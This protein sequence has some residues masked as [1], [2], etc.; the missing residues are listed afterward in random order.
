[1]VLTCTA[2]GGGTSSRSYSFKLL[3]DGRNNFVDGESEQM[4]D[5]GT[6]CGGMVLTSGVNS[7]ESLKVELNLDNSWSK[8]LHS[9][10]NHQ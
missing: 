1:M 4:L 6:V 3:R 5:L 8:Q 2:L 9:F 10:Q 7:I